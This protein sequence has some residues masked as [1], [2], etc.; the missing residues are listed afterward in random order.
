MQYYLMRARPRA[1]KASE[2]RELV[3]WGLFKMARINAQSYKRVDP[4]CTIKVPKLD[5]G[6]NIE[7]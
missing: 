3:F 2:G 5:R 1:N 4:V 7:Q 6:T